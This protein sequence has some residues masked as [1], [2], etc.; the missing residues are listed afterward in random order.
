MANSTDT[1]CAVFCVSFMLVRTEF[2]VSHKLY[3]HTI[4]WI[5]DGSGNLSK[6]S[7]LKR[8]CSLQIELITLSQL[9][10]CILNS[11]IIKFKNSFTICKGYRCKIYIMMVFYYVVCCLCEHNLENSP[12]YS[13]K[14]KQLVSGKSCYFTTCWHFWYASQSFVLIKMIVSEL[15]FLLGFPVIQSDFV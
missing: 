7:A 6:G 15:F 5:K 1:S 3:K 14:K 8:K 12:V 2:D 4:I 10:F 13:C 11:L 9:I